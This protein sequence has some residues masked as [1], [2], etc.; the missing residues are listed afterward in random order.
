MVAVT[1]LIDHADAFAQTGAGG[2]QFIDQLLLFGPAAF[3]LGQTLALGRQQALAVGLAL[4][5]VDADGMLAGDD[6]Q[7]GFQRFYASAAVVHLGRYGMQADS[8]ASAGGVEQADRL[9]RQLAR[10]DVAVRELDR[11]VQGFV[12]NL[13]LM[14]LLH[15][16][17]HAA[18]HQQ[19]LVL[20]GLWHLH[21]LEAAGQ[22]RILL[23]VLLVLG[24]GGGRHGAQAAARQ[25]R[26]EQVGGVAGTGRATGAD[27][28]VGFVDEQDDRLGR[29]LH[30]FDDLA[31]ALLELAF[32]AGAGLQQ[33]DIQAAQL[34][35]LECR[36]HVTGGDAQ[37]ETL[38]HGGLAHAGFTGKDR[39]VLPT[40]H[41][42]ID[43]LADLL[44]ATDDG[45]E[46]ALA[47]LL[48]DVD[49]ETLERLLLAHRRRRHGA[50]GL[51]RCG[52]GKT[53]AG[54]QVVLR[55]IADVLVETLA[56]G[57]HLDLGELA[58]QAQQHLAQARRLED[59]DDQVA[60]TH[61]MLAEHQAAVD[62]ATLDRF[63][64][65]R[66]QVG[67]R[68]RAARQA[69]ECVG[70]VSRQACRLQAEL[71]DDAVQVGVLQLQELVKP[72]RQFD[73][74][75]AAQLAEHG[76][77]L[78]GLVADA[79]EL[80]EQR[81]TT[82][83]THVKFSLIDPPAGSLWR[84]GG[85]APDPWRRAVAGQARWCSPGEPGR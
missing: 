84:D 65:V 13:H 70:Q 4:A 8:H 34:D 75:I 81:G 19:R 24:P 36:R 28:G 63:L 45:V 58:R 16:R 46:L 42:D 78:D 2:Q 44:V 31:Q 21:H 17:G 26:L 61:L 5:D 40:T 30:V 43:Q 47:R 6:L 76:G 52:S 39:V 49:G 79:V 35:V 77:G 32:H 80:A 38:D 64:D 15:G 18:H 3:Q 11:G 7:F 68:G 54:G 66:G 56:Q 1:V 69:V 12:E 55:R 73:V 29:G 67:D 53:V 50:T 37:G 57:L 51:A 48:G 25:R 59:A 71:A 72:V 60:G 83:F 14:V 85:P 22:R 23:D 82:D 62:P 74:G 9:V 41:E 33:A 10:R 20:G 27:Q